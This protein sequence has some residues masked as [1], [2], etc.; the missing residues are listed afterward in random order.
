MINEF[1]RERSAVTQRLKREGE[2]LFVTERYRME[3]SSD[4][5]TNADKISQLV[6]YLDQ[7]HKK[8]KESI[9]LHIEEQSKKIENN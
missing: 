8:I 6:L 5:V 4:T 3:E 2:I 9:A 7:Q 1:I